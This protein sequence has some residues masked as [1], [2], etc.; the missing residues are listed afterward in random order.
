MAYTRPPTSWHRHNATGAAHVCRCGD[1]PCD[2]V[3][4]NTIDLNLFLVFQAIYATGSTTRAGER[5]NLSQSAVSNA[6]RR[7]RERFDDPLFVH[8]NNGMMPTRLAD[9]LIGPIEDGLS[10]FN[11]A[12]ENSRRFDPAMSTQLFRISMNDIGQWSLMPALIA[13]ARFEAPNVRFESVEMSASEW[14]QDM[15]NGSIDLAIGFRSTRSNAMYRQVLFK[16]RFVVLLSAANPIKSERLTL[17]EYLSAE[18]IDYRPREGTHD[19]LYAQLKREGVLHRRKLAFAAAYSHGLAQIVA[20][21]DMLLAIALRAAKAMV[22]SRSGLRIAELPAA[23]S[24]LPPV[25]I[26]QQ[27]SPQRHDDL[28]HQW[29]RRQVAAQFVPHGGGTPRVTKPAK[30][31]EITVD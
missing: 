7:L 14:H 16:E 21:S 3:N 2:S 18:H 5:M 10:K 8:I 6:L 24:G 4:I 19:A 26:T 12:I 11:Q 31:T 25:A 29:L 20:E 13:T 28:S 1:E 9:A 23:L 30:K 15:A 17:D 22:G 27:W